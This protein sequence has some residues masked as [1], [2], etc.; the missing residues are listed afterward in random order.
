MSTEAQDPSVAAGIPLC[1]DLDGTLL[2]TDTLFEAVLLLARRNL[3][4]ALQTCATIFRGRA[5]FKSEVARRVELDVARLPAN[6][7]LLHWLRAEKQRGRCVVLCTAA[8]EPYARA[9]ANHYGLFDEIQC[10]DSTRNLSGRNKGER[11]AARFGERRFDYAGNSA[12]DLP[13]WQRARAAIVVTPTVPLSMQLSRVPRVTKIFARSDGRV[14][15]WLR[16]LRPHQWAKN[17]LV[18]VPALAA[19]RIGEPPVLAA[20]VLAFVAFC[21]AASGTYIVNDLFDLD[22]DRTH[23]KKRERPIASG[24]LQITEGLTAAIVLTGS[25]LLI[26]Y[27]ALGQLFFLVQLGYVVVTLWYSLNLKRRAGADIL[28]LAGLYT[29]RILAGSAATHIEPSFWLLAFSMFLFLSL[30]AAKRSTELAELESRSQSRA[31]GRGYVIGDLPLLLAFGVAAAYSSVLVL[32]LY[33]FSRAETQYS[34]PK[35]LWLLCPVLLYWVSRVWLKTHRR[36]LNEDPV[37]FALTDGPSRFVAVACI[38][39]YW[40][41]T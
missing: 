3:W 12:R 38:V 37:V 14:V 24:R 35:V 10:S 9:V 4:H 7:E 28:C 16:T 29:L 34:H 17:A 25:S 2:R 13:V 6:E 27:L 8:P 32:A 31:P 18:F 26:C 11:L 39:I 40:L 5:A 36:Q 15:M 1:V 19:H 33:V 22:S 21:L 23:P 41:A 30:A 20:S